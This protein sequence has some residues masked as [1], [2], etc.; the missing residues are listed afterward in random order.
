MR[1][2][3]GV[4]QRFFSYVRRKTSELESPFSLQAEARRTRPSSLPCGP[5]LMHT[6][7]MKALFADPEWQAKLCHIHSGDDLAVLV[8]DYMLAKGLT[9]KEVPL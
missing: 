5:T 8:R 9:L 2:F 1:G 3:R 7:V 6:T 4:F